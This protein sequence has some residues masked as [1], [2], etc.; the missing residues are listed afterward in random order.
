MKKKIFALV[1]LGISLSLF[2]FKVIDDRCRENNRKL[3]KE[4]FLYRCIIEGFKERNIEE[5][6]HSGTVY[7]ELMR[8]GIKAKNK[9]DSLAKEFIHSIPI[10]DYENRKTRGITILSIEYYNSKE[11]DKFIKSLDIYMY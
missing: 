5:L 4:Y 10:S 7:V 6:D 11:L 1:L 9:V 3:I 2:S 8:Y